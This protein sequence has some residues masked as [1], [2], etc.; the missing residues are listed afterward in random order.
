MKELTREKYFE[1]EDLINKA[2]RILENTEMDSEANLLNHIASYLRL[3]AD[4]LHLK[5]K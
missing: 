2:E 5:R 1:A 4:I 3:R